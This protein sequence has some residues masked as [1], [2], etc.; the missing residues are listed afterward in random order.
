[1]LIIGKY[2]M[3]FIKTQKLSSGYMPDQ[4]LNIFFSFYSIGLAYLIVYEFLSAS[5]YKLLL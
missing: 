2:H 1:M 3:V 5:N 4:G